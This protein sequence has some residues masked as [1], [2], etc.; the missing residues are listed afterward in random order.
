MSTR[1]SVAWREGSQVTGVYNHSDSYPTGLGVELFTQLRQLGI[2]NLLAVLKRVED[3]RGVLTDG[4]CPYCGKLAGFPHS[5]VAVMDG[6]DPMGRDDFVAMR[7]RQSEGRPALR[8][9]YEH[10]IETLAGIE[11]NRRTTG[12][13]DPAAQFHKHG[14]GKADQFNP[15]ADPADIQ[16]VYVLVPETQMIEVWASVPWKR[17]IEQVW[18][19][20]SGVIQRTLSNRRFTHVLVG[21]VPLGSEPDW[22]E[23]ETMG[24]LARPIT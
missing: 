23:I 19:R 11:H 13:P 21:E 6:F 12:Y 8:A 18:K 16:W 3:W 14:R 17:G 20:T 15:F 9:A 1:G 7:R 24:R 2:D 10:E 4:I 5:V 22:Q